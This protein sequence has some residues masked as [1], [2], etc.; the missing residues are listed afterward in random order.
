MSHLFPI[1]PACFW[2]VVA[3]LLVFGGRLRPCCIFVPDFFR[4]SI[5]NNVAGLLSTFGS[6]GSGGGGGM[7]MVAAAVVLA[8]WQQ[9]KQR[10]RQ[11]HDNNTTTNMTTNKTANMEGG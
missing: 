2:L 10:Q 1:E 11:Q 3:F 6:G 4:C 8:T 9:S 7:P 5:R